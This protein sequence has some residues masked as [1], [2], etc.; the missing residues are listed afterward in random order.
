MPW[1]HALILQ[2]VSY[3][4]HA[5]MDTQEMGKLVQVSTVLIGRNVCFRPGKG[6]VKHALFKQVNTVYIF[7]CCGHDKNSS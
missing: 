4:E 1:S 7:A 2:H 6:L 3:V 5:R